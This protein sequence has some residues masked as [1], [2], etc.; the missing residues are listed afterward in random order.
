MQLVF[1]TN[2]KNKVKEISAVVGDTFT[3]V[4][5]AEIGCNEDIPE[6]NPTI[7]GNASQKAWFVTDKFNVNCFA[8]D[9]GLE[10]EALDGAPGVIS[11][12]FA[13][14]QCS[15]ADNVKKVLSMM[16]GKTN[17]KACFRTIISLVLDGTEYQFEG[18]VNGTILEAPRGGDGFGYDPIF[19]PEETNQSFA[20]MPL[21]EKNAISHRGRATQKLLQFLKERSEK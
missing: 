20:E 5:L 18:R 15:A 13:G 3:V 1:A 10:I 2:N 12:R 7:E 17:R 9:T 16:E 6:T 14:P 11:A 21:D 4:G 19:M 8:D